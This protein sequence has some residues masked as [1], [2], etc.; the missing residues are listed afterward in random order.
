MNRSLTTERIFPM[1]NYANLKLGHT[2]NEIPEKIATNPQAMNLLQYVLLLDVE[3][4]YKKYHQLLERTGG[5]RLEDALEFLE[6]ERSTT[7][8]QLI[9]QTGE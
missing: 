6:Q 8:E 7:F 9:A 5:M 2:L 3:Y 1:G 4:A